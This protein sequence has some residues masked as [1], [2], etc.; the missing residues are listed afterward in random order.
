MNW[1]VKHYPIRK[2]FRVNKIETVL[3][4]LYHGEEYFPIVLNFLNILA[5]LRSLLELPREFS[6][7][8]GVWRLG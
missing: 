7:H 2:Q 6:L 3:E 8:L 5:S 4:T 1:L